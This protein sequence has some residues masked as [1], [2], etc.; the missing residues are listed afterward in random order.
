M[1]LSYHWCSL[2][3]LSSWAGLVKPASQRWQ[4]YGLKTAWVCRCWNIRTTSAAGQLEVR[5][6]LTCWKIVWLGSLTPQMW[7]GTGWSAGLGPRACLT[8]ERL[9]TW[10]CVGLWSG[11][12]CS[13]KLWIWRLFMSVNTGGHWGHFRLCEVSCNRNNLNIPPPSSTAGLT[14][15]ESVEGSSWPEE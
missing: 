8:C 5:A 9:R 13:T 14:V 4:M 6:V 7:Q 3:W 10:L 15:S 2:L 11:T 1:V 12:W